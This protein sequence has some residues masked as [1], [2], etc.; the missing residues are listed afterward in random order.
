M[1][2]NLSIKGVP[3]RLV[4]GLRRRAAAHH[5]SMQG[6]LMALLEEA[7]EPNTMSPH[8]LYEEVSRLGL[9]SADNSVKIIR[10]ARDGRGR[11]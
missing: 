6:E 9:K 10:E 5:R 4:K 3:D 11:R 8:Q 7:I 1:P 2:A